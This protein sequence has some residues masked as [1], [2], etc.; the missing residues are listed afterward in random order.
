MNSK[1]LAIWFSVLVALSVAS[2]WSID[3]DRSARC[4]LDGVRIEPIYRVDLAVDEKITASFCCVKCA[5]EWPNV[6]SRAVWRVR[7][8]VSGKVMDATKACFVISQVVT[9]S[10][11]Q[12][13]THVFEKWT[14]AM[15]HTTQ[16]GG[17]RIDNPLRN[18]QPEAVNRKS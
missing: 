2:R 3:R 6:P 10:S 1:F 8:E 16:F 17:S 13:R 14:D 15:N 12:A 4:S 5:A 9:V 7:D 18:R 11:R